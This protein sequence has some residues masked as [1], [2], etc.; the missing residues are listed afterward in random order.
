MSNQTLQVAALENGTVIDHIP[1]DKMVDVM[2]LLGLQKVQTAVTYGQNL[3]S[4]KMGK[5]GLIKI[6]E[7]F[8]T[9]EEMDQLSVIAPHITLSI[10]RN[11]EVVG[12]REVNL[13]ST[14]RGIVRCNNPKCITN[15]EPMKTLF[16]VS[17]SDEPRLRCHYC[18]KE[19]ALKDIKLL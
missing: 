9:S 1:C 8:L 16:Y 4:R 13:P 14:L 7:R 12:K 19:Q 2:N 18:E 3:E 6:A 17:D 5:K 10:I 15:N 11:Y